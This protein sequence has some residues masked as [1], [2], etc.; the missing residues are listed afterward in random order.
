MAIKKFA[1]DIMMINIL[2]SFAQF[3]REINVERLRDKIRI[4]KEKGLWMG[5][6]AP[7]GYKNKDKK[8]VVNSKTA[9]IVKFIFKYIASNNPYLI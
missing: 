2:C 4:S 1:T 5:G 9:P 7:F 3:E 8:L 6:K